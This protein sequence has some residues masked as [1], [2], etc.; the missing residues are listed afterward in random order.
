MVN[1]KIGGQLCY[2]VA[3][4]PTIGAGLERSKWP[5][6]H[7]H[8]DEQEWHTSSYAVNIIIV[9]NT[10]YCSYWMMM[11]MSCSHTAQLM[12]QQV[13]TIIFR[14]SAWHLFDSAIWIQPESKFATMTTCN[15]YV[16]CHITPIYTINAN[17]YRWT[18]DRNNLLWESVWTSLAGSSTL[19][20]LMTF[21]VCTL[22]GGGW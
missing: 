7:S 15:H 16:Y 9:Y 11:A 12:R 10:V 13:N 18:I 8:I 6:L 19:W 20:P 21:T 22:A 1:A 3:V 4:H 17:D 14:K 2:R 5:Q